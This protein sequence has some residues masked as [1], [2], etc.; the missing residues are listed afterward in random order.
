MSALKIEDAAL[1]HL[2]ARSR[3]VREM[4]RHL[5]RK[6]FDREAI[7]GVIEKFLDYG[8]L[9][10]ERYCHEY[11]RF[12]FGR[13]KGKRRIFAELREKGVE[14]SL[15]ERAFDDYCEEEG[16]PDERARAREEAARVLRMADV[17][18]GSRIPEK[19]LA[20]VARRLASKGYS[21]DTIYS[22]IGEL[23]K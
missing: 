17:P 12:A 13:G 18:E 20:R 2:A 3:T 15:I 23:R 19:V 21:G 7:S 1:R 6:G 11:F 22:V 16:E 10:D 5:D 14:L 8:Y 9:N 4:E